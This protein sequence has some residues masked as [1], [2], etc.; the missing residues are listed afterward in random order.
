MPHCI[1]PECISVLLAILVLQIKN[2]GVHVSLYNVSKETGL[3]IATVYRKS[4]ELSRMGLLLRLGKGAYVVTPKGA[5]YL[6]AYAIKNGG[7][8]HALEVAIKRLK[9]D[10]DLSDV[11]N[12]EVEAYVR[13]LLIGLERLGRPPLGFCAD[14]FGRTV[15]VLLPPKF[16]GRNVVE[17]IAQHLSVPIEMVEKAER[18]IA[19]AILEFF[20]SIKLPDGCRAVVIPQGE[21]GAKLNVLAS[22]CKVKG[23]TL[24]LRCSAGQALLADV[25]K[26]I[27]Q[28]NEKFNGGA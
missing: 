23:Y 26:R 5:F 15:Q 24:G 6:A 17:A 28:N 27:F 25:I 1:A 22:Y 14:D 18:V 3:S 13:L 20:P 8:A 2:R 7:P 10:W 21:Y 12:E 16:G 4:L 11:T 9:S 19:R